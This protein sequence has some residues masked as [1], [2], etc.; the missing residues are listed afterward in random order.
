MRC[1]PG[2][3]AFELDGIVGDGAD[4]HQLGSWK[5]VVSARALNR[6]QQSCDWRMGRGR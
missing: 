4:F 1:A 2:N 6:R 5:P 3:N